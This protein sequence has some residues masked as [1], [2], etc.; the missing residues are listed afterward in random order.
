MLMDVLTETWISA[1]TTDS[2][3]DSSIAPWKSTKWF[4]PDARESAPDICY[5]LIYS[6]ILQ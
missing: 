4:H 5:A 1:K 6:L 3:S 2:P